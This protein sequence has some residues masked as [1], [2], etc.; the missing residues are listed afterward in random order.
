MLRLI[1]SVSILLSSSPLFLNAGFYDRAMEGRYWYDERLRDEAEEPMANKNISEDNALEYLQELKQNF[2]K[3]KALAV[4]QPT[5]ENLLKYMT[6]QNELVINA[7]KFAKVWQQILLENPL[8]NDELTNPT[9]QY[10][11]QARKTAQYT[12]IESVLKSAREKHVLLFVYDSS[13]KLSQA[14]GEMV[15]DFVA[16]THWKI[17]PITVDGKDLAEFPNSKILADQG[18]ALGLK[19]TPAYIIGNIDE[20]TIQHVGFGAISVSKLKENIYT[21]LKAHESIQ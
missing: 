21:Q 13:K 12:E 6:I 4:L 17:V 18:L 11:I 15:Q 14:A 10:A 5:R 1:F 8:L 16:D 2:E 7:E 3:K 19:D 9:A 20:E